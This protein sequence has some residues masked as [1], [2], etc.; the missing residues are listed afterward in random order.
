MAIPGQRLDLLDVEGVNIVG[1]LPPPTMQTSTSSDS[2]ST[3]LGSK[4]PFSSVN[5]LC[6]DCENNRIWPAPREATARLRA[7]CRRDA[8]NRPVDL[9]EALASVD[10]EEVALEIRDEEGRS[11]RL[12]RGKTAAFE[13]M[14]VSG[15]RS[16]R[17]RRLRR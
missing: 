6:A 15:K 17:G 12:R 2:L 13:A 7:S 3:C 14:M 9:R 5:F 10:N 11:S 1:S 8:G 4:S 16:K